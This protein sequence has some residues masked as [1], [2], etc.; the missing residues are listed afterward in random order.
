[1][2]SKRIPAEEQYRLI[3][4]CRQSGLTDHQWC[5]EHDI[6]PGT[7]YNWVKRLRQKGCVD[8]PAS[9]GRTYRA[10]E[11]QEVVRVE[12]HDTDPIPYEQPLNVIP[13]ATERNNFSVAESMKL[14][15]GSFHLTIPNCI[16]RLNSAFF[17]E[18]QSTQI[19]KFRAGISALQ[20]NPL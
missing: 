14:S 7:F 15:V 17:S 3:M 5:V 1:M 18:I 16:L 19:R 4:E 12:F 20:C 11:S 6:K 13:A 2:R 9:T 8:L 10:P